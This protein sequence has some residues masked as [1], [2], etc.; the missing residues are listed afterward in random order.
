LQQVSAD[1]VLARLWQ[2]ET[3]R[4]GSPQINTSKESIMQPRNLLAAAA[5]ALC[6]VIPPGVYA[7]SA[8]TVQLKPQE[9]YVRPFPPFRIVGNVYWVGTYDLAVYLI[10]TPQGHLLINTG[11]NDS[12]NVIK[13]NV[14]KLGFNFADVKVLL[15]THGHWDHVGAFADIKR[16]TGAPLMVHEADAGLVES[17]GNE[18][19][20]FPKG[21]GTTFEPVKVD[22][23][24][25]EGDKV[26]LGGM[27]LTVLHHPGHTKGSASFS[28]TVRDGNRDYNV[29][30]INMGSINPGVTV[31]GME[32]FP[33]ITDAY[34]STLTRQKQ[35][36]P[37]IWLASHAAQ[38]N[39]HQKYKAGD[40][41]DPNRFVDPDGFGAK[42]QF[43][44]KLFRAALQKEREGKAK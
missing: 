2:G 7:Q 18:D 21:R 26:R 40:A 17:G 11:V 8:V 34:A 5:L 38:F 20:R 36:Q 13:S 19:Y 27:E 16:M 4:V 39:L 43:Y 15:A 12:A 32:A 6:A 22:R 9:H 41:Y 28:F 37:D 30:I 31:S 25:R 24:L 29:L 14:E 33:E 44:E 10:T 3:P 23:R 42:I 35:M 1:S